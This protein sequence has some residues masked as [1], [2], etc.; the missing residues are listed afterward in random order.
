MKKTLCFLILSLFAINCTACS[1]N[2]NNSNP[3]FENVTQITSPASKA[4]EENTLK[5]ETTQSEKLSSLSEDELVQSIVSDFTIDGVKFTY[6]KCSDNLYLV[7]SDNGKIDIDIALLKLDDKIS[8]DYINVILSTESTEDICY[9]ALV[10]ALKSDIFNLSLQEQME[11]LVNYKTDKVS[12][13]NE[14]LSISEAQK[15]NIRVIDFN[16]K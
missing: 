16:F 3:T 2:V 8:V 13:E 12:F 9:K 15:D 1:S 6:K 4:V 11:I 10:R 7:N 5:P 14:T